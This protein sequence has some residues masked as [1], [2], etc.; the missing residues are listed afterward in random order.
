M[1]EYFLLGHHFWPVP[2]SPLSREF[3]FPQFAPK[4]VWRILVDHIQLWAVAV[5]K[6]PSKANVAMTP[7]NIWPVIIMQPGICL[8]Y[9]QG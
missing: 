1:N 8:F 7:T 2:V 3:R 4:A 6:L 9:Y 5:Y